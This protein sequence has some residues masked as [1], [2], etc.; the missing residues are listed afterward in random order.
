MLNID[1]VKLI[2]YMN[3]LKSIIDDLYTEYAET[4]NENIHTMLQIH[5]AKLNAIY[6]LLNINGY[7]VDY[8]NNEYIIY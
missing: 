6:T 3:D 7:S 8:I 1:N 4:K 5:S 2:E